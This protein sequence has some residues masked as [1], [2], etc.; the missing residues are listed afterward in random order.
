MS[1]LLLWEI[2]AVAALVAVAG[3]AACAEAA[4]SR[5]SRVRAAELVDDVVPRA[6]RLK[7]VV[8]DP[9]R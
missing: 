4:L 1:A 7:Q 2:V 5:V 8:D 6:S 3:F 9:A